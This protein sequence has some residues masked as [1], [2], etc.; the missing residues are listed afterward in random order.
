MALVSSR[1]NLCDAVLS[2]SFDLVPWWWWML[3]VDCTMTNIAFAT[4]AVCLACILWLR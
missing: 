4:G 1:T 2:G 3:A